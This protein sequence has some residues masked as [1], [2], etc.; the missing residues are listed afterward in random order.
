MLDSPQPNIDISY[1]THLACSGCGKEYP[2]SQVQTYCPDCH[3]PLL[4]SYDLDGIRKNHPRESFSA[5]PPG[6]WRWHELLPVQSAF[7]RI[8][9]G[10]GDTPLLPLRRLGE[11]LG[12][13]DLLLKDEGKNPTASFKARGM[14]VAISRAKELGIR[15][16]ALGGKENTASALAAYAARAGLQAHIYMSAETPPKVVDEI[17]LTGVEVELVK[18]LESSSNGILEEPKQ[19]GWFD[20]STF[21]EPYRIEGQ[22]TIGY[23]IAEALGWVLPDVIICPTGHGTSL[24]SL[25]KSFDEMEALG[26][27][28]DA[29]RPRFVAV[30]ARGCAPIVKAFD[31]E[32]SFCDYWTN[33]HTIASHLIVPKS[34][35]DQLVLKIL[36]ESNGMALSVTEEA[37]QAAQRQMG[38]DEGIHPSFE[39]AAAFA[40]LFKLI[41]QKWVQPSERIVLLNT[42]WGLKHQQAPL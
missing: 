2:A 3:S 9:L 22:K 40:A 35:A 8:T 11:Q 16:V 30:Q 21:H 41:Q 33:A 17:R 39:G 20:L 10:E 23:E 31:A 38:Q 15:K 25:S 14:S 32:A 18:D 24:V 13:S 19:E 27:L 6:M 26:W 5:R 4:V 42:S 7:N 12:L 34:F 29:R 36:Y 1:I 28:E 37:M